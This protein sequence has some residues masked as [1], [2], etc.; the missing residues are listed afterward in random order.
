MIEPNTPQKPT[1]ILGV[2]GRILVSGELVLIRMPFEDIIG[3]LSVTTESG[4][5]STG[6]KIKKP[7]F[8]PVLVSSVKYHD[9][10]GKESRVKL[11]GFIVKS[12]SNHSDPVRWVDGKCQ[13]EK[14]ILLP[15]PNKYPAATPTGFGKPI[16]IPAY[17]GP[18]AQWL[19]VYEVS[20][21]YTVS[22]G[23]KV[24]FFQSI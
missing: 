18:K 3:R 8:H 7:T 14:D 21:V 9:S 4:T 13:D 15:M 12:F 11:T 10:P 1:P 2:G 20:I 17:I 19:L 22:E 23:G 6:K 24:C 16:E 5:V